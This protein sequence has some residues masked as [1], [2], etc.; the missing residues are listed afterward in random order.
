MKFL[1]DECL[2]I[3][4]AVDAHAAGFEAYHVAHIGKAGWQDWNVA[5]FA[6][7]GDL[8]LVTNNGL[9]FLKVYQRGGVHPG[10]VIII[11][12]VHLEAQR[13]LFQAALDALRDISDLRDKSWRSILPI[14]SRWRAYTI[15]PGHSGAVGHEAGVAGDHGLEKPAGA[16]PPLT[17]RCRYRRG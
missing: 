7:R 3:G 14:R 16:I 12:S 8:I 9:D 5:E 15:F 10:L 1:I 17:R 11:P 6:V 13:T 2:T 4:L